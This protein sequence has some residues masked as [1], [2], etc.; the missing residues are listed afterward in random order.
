MSKDKGDRQD[1]DRKQTLLSRNACIAIGI[2]IVVAIAA[3]AG[4]VIL[5]Q[6]PWTPA[7]ATANASETFTSA[8]AL[9]SQSVDLA[10]AGKYKEAL[11]KADAALAMNVS[12]LTPLIQSNRAGILVA[13]GRN[14]EAVAAADASIAVQGNLTTAHAIAWYNKAHALQGLNRTTDA[15][16]AY[17]NASALDPLHQIIPDHL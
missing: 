15:D 6:G 17:A 4:M 16:L 2:V 13:L 5:K 1:T 14:D 7:V 11:D 3:V 10:N 9:Y 8:G 12:S